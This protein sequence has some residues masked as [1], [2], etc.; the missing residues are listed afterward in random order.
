MSDSRPPPE[1]PINKDTTMKATFWF[2][3][4]MGIELTDAIGAMVQAVMHQIALRLHT[5]YWR[6]EENLAIRVEANEKTLRNLQLEMTS[7]GVTPFLCSLVEVPDKKTQ[8]AVIAYMAPGYRI[9]IV[10]EN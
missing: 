7:A 9:E 8:A 4:G 5:E 6:E 3:R 2:A 10:G 1:P